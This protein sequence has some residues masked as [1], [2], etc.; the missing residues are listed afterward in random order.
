[1]ERTSVYE[2]F[3]AQR[4]GQPVYLNVRYTWDYD[5][6]DEDGSGRPIPEA[7]LVTVLGASCANCGDAATLTADETQQAEDAIIAQLIEERAGML[8]DREADGY[9]D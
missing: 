4:N 2:D 1:M 5:P 7:F 8:E 9:G 3:E 6:A